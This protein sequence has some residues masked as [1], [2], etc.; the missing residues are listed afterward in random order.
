MNVFKIAWRSIQHRGI[1]SLLTIISMALGVMMVVSVLT[2]HGLVS[3]SFRSNNSFGY[4][5]IVGARGG[6]LQ[7]TLNSVYYLSNPVE[8]I[9][10]EYYLAFCD[11]ETRTKAFKKSIAYEAQQ[12]VIEATT[13]ASAGL[14]GLGLGSA[15]CEAIAADAF[16]YQQDSAMKI[17][18]PGVYKPY[19]HMAIPLCQGDYYVDPETGA[20]FRCIGTVPNF[21]TDIVLDIDTEETFTFAEGRCFVEE[22]REHGFFECVVG[23]TVARRCDLELGDKIQATHGDPNSDGAH[24]HE[25]NYTIVGIVE[26][27]GTPNDGA[28][29]LN[30]EG[31]F[32]MED[33]AK[34]VEDDSV[35]GLGDEDDDEEDSQPAPVDE[36]F[37]DDDAEEEPDSDPAPAQTAESE[38]SPTEELD[39]EKTTDASDAMV[40]QAETPLTK[41]EE[42]IRKQNATRIPL[43]IEQREV[44]SILIRTSKNDELGILGMF[45]A[46][47]INEGFLNR[48]L[49]WTPYR[50]E[51][52]QTAAQAVNPV[53]EVTSLFEKFVNPIR[54]LLLGLTAMI[55]I[56]S[57]LS[58]LVGIY[59][60]MNQRQGEIAVM[61]ALGAS[62]SK[63]MNIMLC[64]SVMLA[65][66]GGML[67]WIG[68][69]ALNAAFSPLIEQKTGVTTGFLEFAPATD[70]NVFFWGTLPGWIG[71]IGVSPEILLIPALMLLAVLVGIYPALSA[72]RTD[73]S[74]SLGK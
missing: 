20:A 39:K 68:G 67:G 47:Q 14:G 71:S 44:T 10:F 41:E 30:L 57:A 12:G 53:M 43:P 73:V 29:F 55:C 11:A 69:H 38:T 52:A 32:L 58:I 4:N 6:G 25:Q 3:Q 1:G 45:L 65:L 66:M 37:A 24:I 64:E 49:D 59:N 48:T 54:W 40:A 23:S 7:L 27:T 15:I 50:P 51:Q 33:H 63:V 9:P 13:S 60:S 16:Q 28:V 46:P 22:S 21:F 61:R 34:N 5:I 42:F 74:Q 26:A 62:R 56:V 70:L 8:N 19:T 18:K 17:A 36:F 31:F 72:Y 35:L 2:I